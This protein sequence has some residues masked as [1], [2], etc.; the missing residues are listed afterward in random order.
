M[1]DLSVGNEC[2]PNEQFDQK[3]EENRPIKAGFVCQ[4]EANQV[5]K[6]PTLANEL[7]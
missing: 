4:W 1:F 5:L 2:L 6:E 3:E 7:K